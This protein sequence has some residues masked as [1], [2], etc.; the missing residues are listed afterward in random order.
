LQPE[1]RPA[2][3]QAVQIGL[4]LL[5]LVALVL[6][7]GAVQQG[8]L[9]L[10]DMQVSGNGSTAWQLNWYQ[11]RAGSVVP[12][13]WVV[14]VPLTV[15]RFAMLAWALWLAF[16]LLNWLRWGWQCY[17]SGG[18]W[19]EGEKPTKR[20]RWRRKRERDDQPPTDTDDQ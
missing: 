5:T 15:Y 10:P 17:A 16:A 6:L 4:A 14:S 12:Q 9:G 8:L 1:T 19:R 18:L 11:D 13:P 20:R 7:I 2:R 3:F